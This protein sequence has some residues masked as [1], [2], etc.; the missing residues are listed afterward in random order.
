MRSPPWTLA[1]YCS[2]S[3]LD[4]AKKRSFALEPRE[5]PSV[6]LLFV[7]SFEVGLDRSPIEEPSILTHFQ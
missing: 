1:H 2:P 4:F 3:T 7:R 5:Q 6:V